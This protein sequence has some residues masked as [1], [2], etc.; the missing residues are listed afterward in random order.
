M[1]KLFIMTALMALMA[2]ISACA[3]EP[4]GESSRSADLLPPPTCAA[5]SL[6][7]PRVSTTRKV[8]LVSGIPT[9]GTLI[10]GAGTWLPVNDNDAIDVPLPVSVGERIEQVAGYVQIGTTVTEALQPIVMGLYRQDAVTGAPTVLGQTDIGSNFVQEP[11]GAQTLLISHPAAPGFATEDVVNGIQTYWVHF[12]WNQPPAGQIQGQ[13]AI[14]GLTITTSL[15]STTST[16][17][18]C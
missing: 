6:S 3:V 18:S 13:S 1:Y 11:P 10:A 16:T 5:A 4:T 12:R 2:L 7:G 15:P 14:G 17:P 9:G 8:S